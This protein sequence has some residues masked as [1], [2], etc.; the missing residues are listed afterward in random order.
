MHKVYHKI[1]RIAGNVISV[2]ADEVAYRELAQVT[3]GQ[4]V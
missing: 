2:K 1:E 4:G 3:S